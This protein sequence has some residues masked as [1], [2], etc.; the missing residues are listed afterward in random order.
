MQTNGKN[1][2]L[3]VKTFN[4]IKIIAIFKSCKGGGSDK[5]HTCRARFNFMQWAS[6]SKSS[7]RWQST[8]V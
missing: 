8:I 1:R 4:H 7:S 3:D 5:I 2:H 6:S